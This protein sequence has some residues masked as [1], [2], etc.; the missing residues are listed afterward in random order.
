MIKTIRVQLLPNNKQKTLLKKCADVAR[1]AYNWALSKQLENFKNGG[2]FIN[3]GELRK[4]LTQLK[5]NPEYSWLNE[6]S[7]QIPKQAI[8]DLCMAYKRFFKIEN[9]H[10]LNAFFLVFSE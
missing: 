2:K 1:W 9:K 6:V 3:D 7:A 5:K 10:C 4:E 8:K